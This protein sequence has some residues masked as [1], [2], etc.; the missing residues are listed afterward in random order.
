MT[1]LGEGVLAA[2]VHDSEHTEDTCAFC[3]APPKP[4]EETNDFT[5]KCDEDAAELPGL[6]EDGV[7]FKNSA[8]QLGKALADAGFSQI[9]STVVLSG[10]DSI[11]PVHTAAHHLIPGNA[12]LKKSELKAWLHTEG[13]ATGNIGYDVNN[14]ENG[15]W[16]AGNYA[17][18]G[19]DNLP[20]WGTLGASFTLDTGLDPKQ[21]AFAAIEKTRRQFHDAHG[22]YSKFVLRELNLLA[23]KMEETQDLWC[24]EAKKDDSG[25]KKQMFMLVARLNTMSRR[26]SAF[27]TN[28]GKKWREN[29][30]TS[31]F[32][33][34]YIHERLPA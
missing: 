19:K 30:V 4:S 2:L 23:S 15:V 12:S 27:V 21:Y 31:R 1:Q 34:A 16:L 10:L 25:E 33:L 13:K 26:L 5:D 7:A 17:L 8:E 11:L 6:M 32:S 28:P 18:R 29:V 24:P 22:D 9:S 3:H 14:A 20:G